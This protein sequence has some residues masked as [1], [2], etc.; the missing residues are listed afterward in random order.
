MEVFEKKDPWILCGQNTN[1]EVARH[2]LS[3]EIRQKLSL[4]Q[5]FLLPLST[6]RRRRT[7]PFTLITTNRE[8]TQIVLLS[9][10]SQAACW[11]ENYLDQNPPGHFPQ[12]SE[13]NCINFSWKAGVSR[14]GIISETDPNEQTHKGQSRFVHEGKEKPLQNRQKRSPSKLLPFPWK[15]CVIWAWT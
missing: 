1:E 10:L 14:R 12:P 8:I 11:C 15:S 2:S 9:G 3:D 4:F 5:R 7:R 13:V 6:A